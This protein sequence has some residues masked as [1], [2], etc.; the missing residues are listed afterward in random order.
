MPRLVILRVGSLLHR[1]PIKGNTTLNVSGYG[2]TKQD[3]LINRTFGRLVHAPIALTSQDFVLESAAGTGTWLLELVKQAPQTAQ[4]VGIDI[5]SHLFS[6]PT[7]LPPNVS[8]RVQSVLNLPDEWTGK[9]TF[10]PQAFRGIFRALKPGGWLQLEENDN[11]AA[12]P[13]MDTFRSIMVKLG[14]SRNINLWPDVV[15]TLKGYLEECGFVDV[16]IDRRRTPIG[17]WG[18]RDGRDMKDNLLGLFRGIRAPVLARGGFGI[19][20]SEEMY[21]DMMNRAE[22]EMDSASGAACWWVM[23]CARKPGPKLV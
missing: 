13:V 15:P 2:L 12:G 8:F 16:R 1:K 10:W 4:F 3:A 7:A 19:V 20:N 18:G 5:E 9:F 14:E 21:D 22:F 11:W 17:P 6:N 23:I